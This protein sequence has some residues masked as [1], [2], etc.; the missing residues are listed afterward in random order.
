MP[1]GALIGVVDLT[2]VVRHHPSP[3]AEEGQWHWLL[4]NP[5]A[6][7]QPISYRGRQGLFDLDAETAREIARMWSSG[8]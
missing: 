4:A 8:T 2:D 5:I 6:L 3:W 7:S 1:R